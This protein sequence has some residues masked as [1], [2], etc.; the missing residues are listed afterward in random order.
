M[1]FYD[2]L[3]VGKSE[4]PKD[5]RL[6]TV[7]RYVE[8]VENFRKVMNLGKIHLWGSSW[9]GFLAIAYALK[10]QKNLQ[11]LT[12]ASGASSTPLT[13]EGM[14]TLRSELPAALQDTLKKYEDEGDYENPEY[15]QVLDILY[16]KH[17]C[18]LPEWPPEVSYGLSN[19]SKP[20]YQTMWGPNEFVLWGNLMYWDVTDEL[21]GITVPALITCGRYDEVVPSVAEVIHNGIKGSKLMLFENSSHLAFWEERDEYMKAMTDFLD[22]H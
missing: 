1:I 15:L 6:F 11:S 22:R 8:E 10:Y 12:S 5:R 13:Y 3:G 2:Q 16:R 9:G 19:V 14:L 7:E 21:S 4:L 17:I 18:R 20:V